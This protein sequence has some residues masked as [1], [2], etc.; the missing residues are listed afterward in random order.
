MVK[1]NQPDQPTVGRTN[2]HSE[3]QSWELKLHTPEAHEETVSATA[4]RRLVGTACSL[5]H[6]FSVNV[7]VNVLGC[8]PLMRSV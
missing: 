5:S 2:N 7:T 1:G 3:N 6:V 4:W 8:E